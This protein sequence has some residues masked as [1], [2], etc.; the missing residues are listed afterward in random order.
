MSLRDDLIPLVD[1]IRTSVVDEIAGL[2]LHTVTI[3]YVSWTSGTP[4]RGDKVDHDHDLE[5]VPKVEDPSP[6]MTFGQPG[7]FEE[8]D[9]IASR[10]SATYDKA[11][12][13][14]ASPATGTETFWLIDGEEYKVVGEPQEGYLG[15]EVQLRRRRRKATAT[16]A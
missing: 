8:G 6:K 5:P 3:R 15:W 9:R 16:S 14:D 13:Y 4:G 12:L 2:R 11:D 10:I 7:V 1:S